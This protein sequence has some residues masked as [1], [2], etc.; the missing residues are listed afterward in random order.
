MTTYVGYKPST[1]PAQYRA[2]SATAVGNQRA[3]S[4]PYPPRPT[5]AYAMAGRVGRVTVDIPTIR[6]AVWNTSGLTPNALLGRTSEFTA[7]TYMLSETDGTTY[8]ANLEHGVILNTLTDQAVGFAAKDGPVGFGMS[9]P[10]ITGTGGIDNQ[11]YRRTIGASDT[12]QDPF[13][14]SSADAGTG[15][16]AI[17]LICQDMVAPNTPLRSS[18]IPTH[19]GTISDLTPT[20][21]ATFADA[22]LTLPGG[23]ATR[24]ALNQVFIRLGTGIDTDGNVTGVLWNYSYTATA[25]EKAALQSAVDYIGTALTIGNTY[26]WQISFSDMAN[27]RSAWSPAASFTTGAGYVDTTGGVTGKQQT[28]TPGPFTGVWHNASAS[29]AHRFMFRIRQK[30]GTVIRT[31]EAGG[32]TSLPADK[33]VGQTISIT[34]ALTAFTQLPAGTTGANDE[35]NWQMKI[36]DLAGNDTNWSDS[37]TFAIDTPPSIP[38]L[39]SPSDGT[40]ISSRPELV[41][42]CDDPDDTI[43]TGLVVS[44]R[45][46]AS[47]ATTVLQTR[48]M[49]Y[50]A[51]TGTFRYQAVSG[52]MAS[53][54]TFY[55]DSYAFDGTFYSG[56]NTVLGAGALSEMR[57]IQYTAG[58]TVTMTA[59]T[60]DQV[61]NTPTPLI[62]W[63][64]TSQQRFQVTIFQVYSEFTSIRAGESPGDTRTIYQSPEIVSATT[65]HR[66]PNGYLEDDETY[67]VVV[68]AWNTTGQRGDS[69]DVRF[70]VNTSVA[71]QITGF[72]VFAHTVGQESEPTAV[73]FHWDQ[74]VYTSLQFDRYRI[75]E[76]VLDEG[77]FDADDETAGKNR[78]IAELDSPSITS[79]I[80]YFPPADANVVYSIKQL[81]TIDDGSGNLTEQVSAPVYQELAIP[82]QQTIINSIEFPVSRRLALPYREERGI[83]YPNSDPELIPIWGEGAPWAI[84]DD[85]FYREVSGEYVIIGNEVNRLATIRAMELLKKTGGPMVYRDGRRHRWYGVISHLDWTDPPAGEAWSISLTFTQIAASQAEG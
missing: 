85:T 70:S 35:L 60:A 45:I 21:K 6:F 33:T 34:W 42:T 7:G 4:G 78:V 77:L 17:W 38:A 84:E 44:A 1:N 71:S 11:L 18:M 62:D 81:V 20:L 50:D 61:F 22:D 9:G 8:T 31:T 2:M 75:M 73:E 52:D 19:G 43:G 28:R 67:H 40:L 13:S 68:T 51:T 12:P 76:R 46:L 83:S 3:T 29:P 47:D 48:A 15:L 25:A 65:A 59:P 69:V 72:Q 74:T 24:D 14:P 53:A 49:T 64:F 37:Q 79:Y 39:I 57:S 55:W 36:Q 54:G 41:V 27:L 80:H 58:P 30:D 23:V 26:Y 5:Q 66:V 63:G 82:F 16:M 32:W 56:G 10:L